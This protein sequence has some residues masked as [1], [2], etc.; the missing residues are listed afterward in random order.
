M[1]WSWNCWLRLG[2]GR[3]GWAPQRRGARGKAARGGGGYSGGVG[4]G[5][6][7]LFRFGG[8]FAEHRMALG[9][10]NHGPEW[11]SWG[12]S[13]GSGRPGWGADVGNN[14]P[15]DATDL[16]GGDGAAGRFPGEEGLA[17]Q[18]AGQDEGIVAGRV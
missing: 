4:G 14:A 17:G 11:A 3:V 2:A 9:A 1:G 16:P 15:H 6:R 18:G 10:S 5:L 8:V 7:G 13:T 12:F